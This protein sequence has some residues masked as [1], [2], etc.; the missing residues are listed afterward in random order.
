MS[1]GKEFTLKEIAEHNTKKD[2]FMVIHDKVYD[3]TSFVDEHPYVIPRIPSESAHGHTMPP[4]SGCGL[5]RRQPALSARPFCP[6]RKVAQLAN[7]DFRPPHDHR[8]L[9]E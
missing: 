2:L 8:N 9:P 1:D 7:A 6:Y 5:L 4:H 3:C